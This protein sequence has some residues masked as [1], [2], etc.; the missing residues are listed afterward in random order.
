[1]NH[2]TVSSVQNVPAWDPR[3]AGMRKSAG[4]TAEEDAKLKKAC[5]ELEGVFLNLLLKTMRDTVPKS[6]LAGSGMQAD[7]MQ[8]MFDME[9]TR[10]MATGGGTGIADMLYRNLTSR[11][12]V[13]PAATPEKK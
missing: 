3:V 8:S 9:M 13:Q 5:Q 10:S 11:A 1:M 2:V 6:S 4:S 7:T 12:G